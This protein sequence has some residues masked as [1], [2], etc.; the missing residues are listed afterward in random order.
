MTGFEGAP[1][2]FCQTK[3]MPNCI[4]KSLICPHVMRSSLAVVCLL[5]GLLAGCSGALHWDEGQSAASSAQRPVSRGEAAG[6]RRQVA[7]TATKMIGVPYRYGGESPSGFDCSGL[8]QYSYRSAGITVPRTSREQYRAANPIRLTEA[9]PGDLLFFRYDN[10][11]SHVAIY[12]G[13]ERFVH[14]PSSGKQV[15][16]ASLRDPHYQQHFV[17]A[18]RL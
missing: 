5:S 16:V 9:V 15:S 14:A 7:Q 4:K 6:P 10:R 1:C 3:A 11:I 2:L 17:Q 8:V 12:L 13:D 18:G